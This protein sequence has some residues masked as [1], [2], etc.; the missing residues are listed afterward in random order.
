MHQLLFSGDFGEVGVTLGADFRTIK[1]IYDWV[2]EYVTAVP[3]TNDAGATLDIEDDGTAV[4][5]GIDVSTAATPGEW[6]STAVG[7]TNAPVSITAG[8]AISFTAGTIDS[9]TR[10][11]MAIYGQLGVKPA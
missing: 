8:S 2:I 4:I 3:S 5:A 10:I 9:G 6:K 7:G 1:N 11:T